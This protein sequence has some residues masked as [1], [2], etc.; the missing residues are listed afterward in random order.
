M[1]NQIQIR[2]VIP[3]LFSFFISCNDGFIALPYIHFDYGNERDE[4][5]E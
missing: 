5:P 1:K 4:S 3:V 2:Q